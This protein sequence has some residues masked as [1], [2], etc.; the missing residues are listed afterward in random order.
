M[1]DL[2]VESGERR[3]FSSAKMSPVSKTPAMKASSKQKVE[4]NTHKSTTRDYTVAEEVD[5]KCGH[6]GGYRN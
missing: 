1:C 5:G 6:L 2:R 3:K 4:L